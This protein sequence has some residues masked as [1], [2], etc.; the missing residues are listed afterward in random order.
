MSRSLAHAVC[1][2]A[3]AAL[4]ACATSTGGLAVPLQAELT[5][6]LAERG[7]RSFEVGAWTV[8]L[9][10]ADLAVGPL[11]LYAE[12]PTSAD[13]DAAG[14]LVAEVPDQ[15]VMDM[16]SDEPIHLEHG[17]G[18]ASAV[19][20]AELWLEPIDDGDTLVVEGVAEHPD[21]GALPFSAAIT[22]EAP[23][24][25][26]EE[27]RNPTLRRRIRGL[28]L[29]GELEDGQRLNILAEPAGW[30][31]E[32]GLDGLLE[33]EAGEDGVRVLTAESL[34]GRDLDQGVR[35]TAVG[36]SWTLGLSAAE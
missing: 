25:P 14:L 30:F 34:P 23:W 3:L 1:L 18:Q 31:T 29:D 16:L 4:T 22:W 13:V 27:G 19:G 28:P 9:E 5:S 26:D 36:T 7:E 21:Q 35:R 17:R 11:Y 12:L 6:A 33:L 20:S 8:T 2:A 32:P 15:V 10:R 24:V